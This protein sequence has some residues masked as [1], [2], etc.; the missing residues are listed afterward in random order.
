M[1]QIWTGFFPLRNHLKHAAAE[2][3]SGIGCVSEIQPA[4][5]TNQNKLWSQKKKHANVFLYA[6]QKISGVLVQAVFMLGDSS[7]FCI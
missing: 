7:C 3:G 4:S 1:P 2:V 5:S 6:L